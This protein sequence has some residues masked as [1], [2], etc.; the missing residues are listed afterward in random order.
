MITVDLNCDMGEGI[1]NDADIMPYISSTNI[2]CGFHAGDYATIAQTT[3][4]ALKHGVSIGA[5]PA[6]PDKQNFGRTAMN[7]SARQVYEMILYQVGAVEAIVRSLGG[8]LRH[9][10]PHGALYNVAAINKELGLSIASAVKDFNPALVL[11]GLANSKLLEAARNIGLVFK[12]EVFADRT[13]QDDG[14]L[15]SRTQPNA[16]ITNEEEC[17]RQVLRMIKDGTVKSV[18]GKVIPIEANTICLHGDG[19]N[20]VAFAKLLNTRLRADGMKISSQ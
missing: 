11:I 4:L 9:I 17:L 18:S 19:E 3:R 13:Y 7:F 16:L 5:H 6:Y 12:H 20:A 2:A 8:T 10:K 1:G 15:T 14:T